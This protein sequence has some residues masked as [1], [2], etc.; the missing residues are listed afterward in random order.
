MTYRVSDFFNNY[1]SRVKLAAGIGGL[2]KP[3]TDTGILDYEMVPSLKNKYFHTNFHEGQF[4]LTTFLYARDN[5]Y[6]ILDAV[7]HLAAKETSG[8]VIKNVFHLPI[9]DTVI[10]FA[11]SRN[12]PIFVIDTADL[13]VER[14]IADISRCIEKYDDMAFIQDEINRLL[15]TEMSA[16]EIRIQG[17]RI[18]PSYEEQFFHVYLKY[19]D[20][21]NEEYFLTCLRAYQNSSLDSCSKSFS[22]FKHGILFTYSSENLEQNRAEEAVTRLLELCPGTGDQ[23][24]P[25]LSAGVS[26]L[27]FTLEEY[28]ESIFESMRSGLFF[29]GRTSR[30]IW[31]GDLGTYKILLP[32][33]QTREMAGF[34]RNILDGVLDYDAEN[35]TQLFATL[36]CFVD[37]DCNIE[38]TASLMNQHKNTIRYRMDR[39][40][41]ITGLDYKHYSAL[42]ELVLAVKI[43]R[44]GEMTSFT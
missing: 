18:N 29:K 8:L 24:T 31:Y 38:Q 43:K 19:G 1:G 4:V 25:L 27:H 12:F 6:L 3:I 5:P 33:F 30:P 2:S 26:A 10:R 22:Y 15:I 40:T 34:S 41:E 28:K 14:M 44:C 35:G 42:E 16:S 36:S 11:D 39:I 37:C 23:T 32:F 13:Y 9:H 7:K 20:E 17:K 21:F